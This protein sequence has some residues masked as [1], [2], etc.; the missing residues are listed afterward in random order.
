M[1]LEYEVTI[2]TTCRACAMA[3]AGHMPALGTI[4]SVF[5][6]LEKGHL[7]HANSN[8][9]VFFDGSSVSCPEH[10]KKLDLASEP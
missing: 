4:R 6:A 2:R 9:M 1:S 7:L 5:V 8:M 10:G 3:I